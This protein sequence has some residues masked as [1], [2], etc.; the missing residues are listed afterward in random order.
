M[1]LKRI[2]MRLKTKFFKIVM[3]PTVIYGSECGAIGRKI[4][5]RTGVTK[6]NKMINKY[7]TRGRV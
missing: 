2:P 4:E 5:Y 3:V 7:N 1:C 6:E